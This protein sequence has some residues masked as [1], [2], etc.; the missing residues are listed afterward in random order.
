MARRR[1][2]PAHPRLSTTTAGVLARSAL[3]IGLVVVASCLVLAATLDGRTD[4]VK[5]DMSKQ[6]AAHAAL[7]SAKG[8]LPTDNS[9][10]LLC[11]A[12]FTK[13]TI[14]ADHIEHGI[15]C[16]HCHGISFE[17]MD[18]ETSRTKP[19][20]LF[21]RAEVAPFCRR[22]HDDHQ[23]PAKVAAFLGEWKSKTRPNGRVILE[24][25]TCTDCH[26]EHVILKVP[27]VT[28]GS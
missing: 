26:G 23:E 21:G 24:Q 28:D 13:E 2:R 27:V 14:V 9:L 22:C 17:H 12:N 3:I 16:V 5:Q 20:I 8:A 10:C 6:A 7:Y 15:T 11:H 4:A 18:D 25:A 19:D 1:P